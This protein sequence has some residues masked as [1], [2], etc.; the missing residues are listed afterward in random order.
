M[1]GYF[2]INVLNGVK[3]VKFAYEGISKFFKP[4]PVF[5]CDLG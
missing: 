3:Y 5:C 1:G 4:D 2:E